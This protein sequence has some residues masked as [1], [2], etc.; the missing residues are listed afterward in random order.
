MKT[1]ITLLLLG[2]VFTSLGQKIK[3][4]EIDKFNGLRRI[5]TN[6]VTLAQSWTTAMDIKIRSADTSI[7]L[8]VRGS[9]GVIGNGDELIFLLSNGDKI[10]AIST[11]VQSALLDGGFQY[12]ITP[13]AV[14][15]LSKVQITEFRI[16]KTDI[17]DDQKVQSQFRSYLVK[18]FDIFF[19]EYSK[20]S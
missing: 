7:F 16:E 14:K 9:S 8:F 17:Y 12:K 15:T 3:V 2:I 20:T 5:E 10:S 11:A 4:N 13:D 1:L 6:Y 18:L 19:K